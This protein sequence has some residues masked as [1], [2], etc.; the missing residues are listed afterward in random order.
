MSFIF[1]WVRKEKITRTKWSQKPYFKGRCI[2]FFFGFREFFFKR[3]LYPFRFWIFYLGR[4][5]F[6]KCYFKFVVVC[7]VSHN[8]LQMS[9]SAHTFYFVMCKFCLNSL[10]NG[11][12]YGSYAHYLI[13]PNIYLAGSAKLFEQE[14]LGWWTRM[15]IS[16][17]GVSSLQK[18]L[19]FTQ[20]FLLIVFCPVI[21]STKNWDIYS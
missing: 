6:L 18:V 16:V 20:N 2:L 15:L 3:G 13:L 4:A 7:F 8:T 1:R 14:N 9:Y 10:K 12:Q 11:F 5:F 17:R 21:Y 19:I